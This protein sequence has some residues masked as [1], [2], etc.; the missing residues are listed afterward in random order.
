MKVG[1]TRRV[2]LHPGL[3]WTLQC[4]SPGRLPCC[5]LLDEKGQLG[6]LVGDPAS[7]VRLQTHRQPG[8]GQGQF[9]VVPASFGQ[10]TDRVGQQQ[11]Q[12]PV[13]G[14]VG[15][16]QMAVSETPAWQVDSQPVVDLCFS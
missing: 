10:V 1:H 16:R 6:I 12:L 4:L 7:I 2:L 9:W 5:D 15:A 3:G 14:A 13:A 11:G 8:I